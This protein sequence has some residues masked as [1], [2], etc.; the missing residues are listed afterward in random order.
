VP[1]PDFLVVGAQKAAT[2]TLYEHLRRHPEVFVTAKKEPHFFCAPSPGVAPAW[3]PQLIKSLRDELVLTPGGY[4]ALFAP[5]VNRVRGECSTAYL[6]DPD[7]PA[8]AV[9][10]NA[11]IRVIAILRDPVERAYS[12]WWMYHRA[13][14]DPLP[15][16][17]ALA[18]EYK[19]QSIGWG[20][21]FAYQGNGCYS[22]HLARWRAAVGDERMLVLRYE[23]FVANAAP[24]LTRVYEFLGVS[25]PAEPVAHIVANAARPLAGGERRQR[26][27]RHVAPLRPAIRR[28]LP[29]RTL[30]SA[31]RRLVPPATVPTM[32]PAAGQRLRESLLSEIEQTEIALG[33]DLAAWKI[34]P[35]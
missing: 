27:V 32:D 26:L 15:F 34:G 25:T 28:V 24:E 3:K 14:H 4:E 11:D 6:C 17:A 2:T 10:A 8:R 7:V 30:E 18:A 19:R 20:L 5:G 23:D 22:T 12:A 29:G 31:T 9:A 35:S 1:V 16:S 21:P 33:W 13:H